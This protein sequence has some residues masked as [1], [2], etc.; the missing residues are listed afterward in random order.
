MGLTGFKAKTSRKG[1]SRSAVKALPQEEK[2]LP[3]KTENIALPGKADSARRSTEQVKTTLMTIDTMWATQ[4]RRE[5]A[6]LANALTEVRDELANNLAKLT[7]P[8]DKISE[9]EQNLALECRNLMETDNTKIQKDIQDRIRKLEGELS[10]IELERQARLEALSMN[11]AALRSQINRICETFRRLLHED[12]MLAK[13][14]RTIFRE[15]GITTASILTAMGMTIS[16]PV[17][18]LNGGGGSGPDVPS[19]APKPSDKGGLREWVK[20]HLQALGRAQANLA[21]KATA[22]L[23]GIIGSIVSWLLST[24]GKT[25]ASLAG[26]LWAVGTAAGSLF[27]VAARDWLWPVRPSSR[28]RAAREPKRRS[29]V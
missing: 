16:T 14:I 7:A 4:A 5:L 6:G 22:A 11:R 1:L 19:Q 25:A 15:Q 24:L 23:P 18:A 12:T 13:C 28:P 29:A 10:D 9:A 2:A 26:T 3:S 17:L 21:G 27:L 20:K 8:N